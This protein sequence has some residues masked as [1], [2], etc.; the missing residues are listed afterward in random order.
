MGNAI[1]FIKE[2]KNFD[3]IVKQ[4]EQEFHL[5]DMPEY[6]QEEFYRGLSQTKVFNS[7]L[8]QIINQ[9]NLDK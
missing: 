5:L 3:E 4:L 1:N 2:A 7:Y 8:K 6:V 9:S